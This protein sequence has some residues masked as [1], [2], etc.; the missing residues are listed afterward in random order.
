MA[1]AWDGVIENPLPGRLYKPRTTGV[2]M[3]LDKGCGVTVLEDLLSMA[4]EYVDFWKITFGTSVTYPYYVLQSKLRILRERGVSACP[5]G[6]LFEVA[7]MQGKY[8]AFLD[9]LQELGFTSIEIS[10][11]TYPLSSKERQEAIT[12]AKARK[13]EVLSE[14][15][16]K[17]P[18]ENPEAAFLFDT[19][20][21][22]LDYGSDFVIVEGR[23]SGKGVGIYDAKGDIKQDDLEVLAQDTSLLD[24]IIW[25]APN[26]AQQVALIKR[27]GAN[28]NL[29][30]IPVE[31]IIALE[32]LRTGLR[33]DTLKDV[34]KKMLG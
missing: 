4:S 5:G 6:T 30:N 20:R 27:F 9:R 10:D 31:E 19:L 24:R 8:D 17:D 32:A 33:G 3:V 28:V 16:K 29:G 18:Q 34:V 11:G 1:R 12:K 21:A 15:G 14:V 23:E 22:D 25:E 7:W 2:T 13:L 26:K